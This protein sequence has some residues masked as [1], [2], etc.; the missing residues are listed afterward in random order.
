MPKTGTK[1]ATAPPRRPRPRGRFGGNLMLGLS[2]HLAA[3]VIFAIAYALQVD[4]CAER[5]TTIAALAT[6][7]GFDVLIA[8]VVAF[9]TRRRNRGAAVTAILGWAASFV[10]VV[11]LFTAAV[12][13]ANSLPTGCA[14]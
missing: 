2:V 3:A 4:N 6:A 8:A 7:A 5:D 10:L 12:A 9:F 13:Y 14:A 11:G 1:T